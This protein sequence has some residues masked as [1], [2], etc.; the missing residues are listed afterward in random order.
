MIAVT[1]TR[2]MILTP[3]MRK[4]HDVRGGIVQKLASLIL[5]LFFLLGCPVALIAGEWPIDGN[6]DSWHQLE[7]DSPYT[8]K[9]IR[10]ENHSLL[11]DR[12]AFDF[13]LFFPNLYIMT[14]ALSFDVSDHKNIRL[15]T[16]SH[17]LVLQ[18]DLDSQITL[19]EYDLALYYDIP[20]VRTITAD[21]LNID[22]GLNVRAVDLEGSTEN[23]LLGKSTK[24]FII[25]IPMVFG[26]FQFQPLHT[27]ALE[28]EGRGISLG[29]NKA[30]SLVGR[31]RWN[32]MDDVYAAGGYRY[33][34][35]DI[36]YQGVLIDTDISGPFFE[37]GLAF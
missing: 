7:N 28:A 30:F 21:M 27:L 2:K 4:W 35:F 16:G 9:H 32:L 13:P 20:I 12:L 22:L 34:K 31:I 24:S 26:A 33:D 23:D 18:D 25:P 5:C 11:N 29:A 37:A 14:N 3:S 10:Y 6:G 36:D 19:N 15:Q 1:E 8:R 17:E